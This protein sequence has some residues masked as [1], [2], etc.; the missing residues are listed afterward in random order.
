MSLRTTCALKSLAAVFLAIYS[1]GSFSQPRID[2]SQGTLFLTGGVSFK[3]DVVGFDRMQHKFSL[4]SDLGGGYFVIDRLSVGASIPAEWNFASGL[5]SIALEKRG[6]IGLKVFS[7]Y[8]FDTSFALFPYIGA[9]ATPAYGL[10]EKAFVL[11]AGLDGGVLVS[12]TESVALDFG[13][14][15]ELFIKLSST[16]KW[17][18]SLPV[19]FLGIR[20]VF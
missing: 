4:L 10:G 13:L 8:F 16:Q 15:P 9:N 11:S 12:L 18:L 17:R 5:D 3:Y 19:G 20:A 7:T 2:L 14:R 1:I 6:R